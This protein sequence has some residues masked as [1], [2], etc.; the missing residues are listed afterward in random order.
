LDVMLLKKSGLTDLSSLRTIVLFP[1]D[2]NFAF[3][4]MG[5]AMMKIVEQTKSLAP[6]QYHSRKRHRAIDLAVSKALTLDTL[7]DKASRSHM[8]K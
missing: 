1:V 4:H 2:Y 7:P 5:R 8:F 6:E 3:K